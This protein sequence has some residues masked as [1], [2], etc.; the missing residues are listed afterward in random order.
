[1]SRK[2]TK[3]TLSPEQLQKMKEGR[4]RAREQ[5]ERDARVQRQ[6]AAVA[7]IDRA[8]N[9]HSSNRPVGLP[10]HRRRRTL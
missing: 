6:V 3:R 1:M 7:D 10:R 2:R 4:E 8:I 9:A 5:R